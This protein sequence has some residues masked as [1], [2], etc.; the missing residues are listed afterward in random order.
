MVFVFD[1]DDTLSET[2]SYS[3]NYICDFLSA[4]NLPYKLINSNARFADGK[5]DWDTETAIKWYKQFGDQMMTEF[6]CKKNV[7]NLLQKIHAAGH[8]IVIATARATDWHTDPEGITLKWLAVNK[9]PYDDVYIGRVD[10][11]KICEE[12]DADFFIDDDLSL[13]GRVANFFAQSRKHRQAFLTT[14]NFNHGLPVPNGV[15]RV[16]DFEELERYCVALK[17]I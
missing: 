11:E 8:R 13:T 17:I 5:F 14:T 10:K 16:A 4:H 15:I 1:L 3:E 12:V 6:P 7:V 2:D 9:I